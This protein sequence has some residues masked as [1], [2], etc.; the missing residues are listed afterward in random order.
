[1]A[2]MVVGV[3]PVV[4]APSFHLWLINLSYYVFEYVCHRGCAYMAGILGVR[5][6]FQIFGLTVLSV[7]YYL[8]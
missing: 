3:W 1:M 7:V 6:T 5:L 8:L 4:M 2:F